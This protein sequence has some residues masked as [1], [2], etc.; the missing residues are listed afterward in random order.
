MVSMGVLRSLF[1]LMLSLHSSEINVHAWCR[2]ERINLY[3][4]RIYTQLHADLN[5]SKENKCSACLG[6]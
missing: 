1:K 5:G 6:S 2:L 4:I 3:A